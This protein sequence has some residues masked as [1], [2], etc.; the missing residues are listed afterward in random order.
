VGAFGFLAH[1]A[2]QAEDPDNSTGNMAMRDQR[3]ALLWTQKNVANFGGDPTQVTLFGESAGAFSVCY[4]LASPLSR[5]LFHAAIMESGTCDSPSF[6]Q[7]LA[8]ATSFGDI[9]ANAVGCNSTTLSRDAFLRCLRA[10]DTAALIS[11]PPSWLSPDWPN[12]PAAGP[13]SGWVSAFAPL[14]PFGPCV[15]GSP[16][17]PAL[18]LALIRAGQFARVPLIIG[19]NQNEGSIFLAALPLVIRHGVTFPLSNASVPLVLAHIFNAST[20]QLI[21]QE[22]PAY[23]FSDADHRVGR[24][25]RDFFFVCASRR[26]AR[27]LDQQGVP[28]FVYHFTYKGDWVED[29]FLGV[30][31]SSELEFVWGNQWPPLVHH[32]SKRDRAM[33]DT[34]QAFW[35]ALARFGDPNGNATQPVWPRFAAPAE[36]NIVLDVPVAVEASYGGALCDFWDTTQETP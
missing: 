34:F 17:L 23:E 14:M 32:F 12:P 16:E 22:Y 21:L 1:A 10:L 6:F 3:A 29:P 8:D 13:P 24:I 31:H 7:P 19:T 2:L 36:Q 25:I 26:V 20:V 15:D 27:A 28:A 4:H 33:S 35:G 9:F 18:P 11:A 5:G 30:Y